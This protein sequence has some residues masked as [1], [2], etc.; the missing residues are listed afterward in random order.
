[1][2]RLLFAH[3]AVRSGVFVLVLGKRE[4]RRGSASKAA[5]FGSCLGTG[6]GIGMRSRFQ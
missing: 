4:T 6:V 1:M 3:W 5:G 2:R